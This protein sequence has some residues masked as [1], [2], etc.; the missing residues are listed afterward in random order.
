[1]GDAGVMGT[2][3]ELTVGKGA[4]AALTKLHV[5]LGIQVSPL[6]EGFHVSHTLL[7]GLTTLQ[8]DGGQTGSSQTESRQQTGGATAHHHRTGTGG[9]GHLGE[10]VRGGLRLKHHMLAPGTANHFLLVGNRNIHRHHIVD[11]GLL[12]GV[13]G[14]THRGALMDLSHGNAQGFGRPLLQQGGVSI[15]RQDQI[16]DSYHVLLLSSSFYGSSRHGSKCLRYR[17]SQQTRT[18]GKGSRSGH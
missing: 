7:Q 11:V 16:T 14:L 1:M 8:Q 6:P 15:G 10:L 13:D 2:G 18:W 4:C 9:P 3:G 17:Q 5:G 12:S